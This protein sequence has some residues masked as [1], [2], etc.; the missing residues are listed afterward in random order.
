[1]VSFGRHKGKLFREV[2]IS[3]FCWSIQEVKERGPDGS[4]PDLVSLS[5]YAAHVLQ[6]TPNKMADLEDYPLVPIPADTASVTSWGDDH[7]SE[8]SSEA[9]SMNSRMGSQ[10][11]PKAAA[12]SSTRA[13][14]VKRSP[15]ER[16]RDAH[17]KGEMDQE[18]PPEVKA[19]VEELMTRLAT[20]KDKFNL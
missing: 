17:E 14:P 19:E 16:G 6:E 7:W 18:V 10:S 5:T 2:P 11:L 1:M 8:L 13:S 9:K 4:S 20:L 15:M 3:Y 12:K